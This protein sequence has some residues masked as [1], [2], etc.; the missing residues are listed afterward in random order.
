MAETLP[1]VVVEVVL[2]EM[3]LTAAIATIVAAVQ[4]GYCVNTPS[5][6]GRAES[7]G[8]IIYS[9]AYY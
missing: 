4:A 7:L 5:R 2:T 8:K 3:V 6:E 9:R 1:A